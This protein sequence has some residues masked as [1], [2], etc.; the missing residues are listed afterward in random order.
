MATDIWL[1]NLHTHEARQATEWAGTDSQPMWHGD[2]LYYMSD[3][4]PATTG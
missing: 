2:Q 1:F 3:A 4:G